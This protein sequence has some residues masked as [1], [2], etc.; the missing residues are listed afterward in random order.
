VAHQSFQGF[1]IDGV[2]AS[3]LNPNQDCYQQLSHRRIPIIFYNNYYRNL[4]YPRVI[5]NDLKC[6]D[7]L[8]GLLL[9]AGHRNLASI[10]VY[11]N[12][13]SIEKFQGMV[14]VMQRYGVEFQDDYV[15]WCVSNEAHEESFVRS[16]EKFLRGLPHC[17]A[18]ICCN[19]IIYRLTRQALEKMGKKVPED[20][21]L[22]CFD[23]SG[24]DWV[25]EGITCS[26]HQ[27]FQMGRQVALQL[28]SMMQNR[29]S[30]DMDCSC[31]MDP[32]IYVGTSIK[33]L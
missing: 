19:Y 12:Y 29:V 8:V 3:L 9:Q 26:I 22:V 27:G 6:A 2:K 15:K 1:I 13:Q 28:M 21:S 4:R 5:V 14:A 30:K 18:I 7:Q 10:F 31:V 11:D 25:E 32:E 33:P 17:T 24:S 20:Y 23:Y 16:I